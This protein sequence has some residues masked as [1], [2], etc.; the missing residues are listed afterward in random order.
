MLHCLFLCST[1]IIKASKKVA[2]AVLRGTFQNLQISLRIFFLAN[3]HFCL[4]KSFS[5]F[6]TQNNMNSYN[7]TTTATFTSNNISVIILTLDSDIAYPKCQP[8][9]P[10]CQLN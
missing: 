2:A 4:F 8:H 10:K 6:N 5:V 3:L 7:I 1:N 9:E